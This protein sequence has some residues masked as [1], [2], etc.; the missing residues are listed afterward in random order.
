MKKTLIFVA[1]CTLALAA[2]TG[3]ELFQKAVTQERAAGNLEEAIKLYQRVAKEYASDRPLAAKALVQAARCYEKLGKD[4]SLKIYE[5][6]MKEFSDQ[7]EPAT[8]A[9]ERLAVLTAAAKPK[10]AAGMVARQIPMPFPAALRTTNGRQIFYVNGLGLMV[11]GMDA[12]EGR[13]IFEARDYIRGGVPTGYVVS[14]DGKQIAFGLQRLG[15]SLWVAAVDGSGGR[16]LYPII[17]RRGLRVLDWSPDNTR[18][19]AS[20]FQSDGTWA[21]MSISAADG[22]ARKLT[23]DARPLS[24]AKFSPD[25]KFV[26]YSTPETG[27]PLSPA[28]VYI[29]AVD[30]GQPTKV[31]E[32]STGDKLL[33]WMPDGAHLLFLSDRKGT[34]SIFALPISQGRAVGE[35]ILVKQDTG[36]ITYASM[37]KEGTLYYTVGSGSRPELHLMSIDPV[38]R[39]VTSTPRR[40]ADRRLE[41]QYDGTWSPDGRTLAYVAVSAP[42]RQPTAGI[43]PDPNSVRLVLQTVDSGVEREFSLGGPATHLCWAPQGDLIYFARGLGPV[44]Q[45]FNLMSIS[46]ITGEIKQVAEYPQRR[47]ISSIV[48][49]PDGKALL[50][51]LFDGAANP[52]RSLLIRRDLATGEETEIVSRTY[53]TQLAVSRDG[54]K[55]AAL[56]YRQGSNPTISVKPLNGGEWKRIA[57]VPAAVL[58]GLRWAPTGDM[59]L[60]SGADGMGAALYGVDQNGGD[61]RALISYPQFKAFS[62]SD[63]HPDGRQV[64][65]LEVVGEAE[66]WALENITSKLKAAR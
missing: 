56:E 15:E 61:V 21:L 5:Q 20:V 59:I 26:A 35:P 51:G 7:R 38:N 48:R 28:D 30:G 34:S 52:L 4:N 22:S 14:R 32:H 41:S 44:V 45:R 58:E 10:P 33:D 46:P 18:I 55:V 62:V 66:L 17:R 25:G 9:R 43:P 36:N 42:Q 2:E 19:L 11:T 23:G 31:V 63:F 64:M 24:P 37:S 60:F 3:P 13:L 49:S 47:P 12:G 8:A 54:T 50:I 40:V 1:A 29:M 39:R 27:P 65:F 53:A 57:T 6:V 16:E